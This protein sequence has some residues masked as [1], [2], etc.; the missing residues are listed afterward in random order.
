MEVGHSVRHG[1]TFVPMFF[2]TNCERILCTSSNQTVITTLVLAVCR[3][4]C[5]QT[6]VFI[7]DVAHGIPDHIQDF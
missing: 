4:L 7:S 2:A 6:S 1:G 5:Y 3:P